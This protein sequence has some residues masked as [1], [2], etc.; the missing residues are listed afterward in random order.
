[1]SQVPRAMYQAC[2]EGY[3]RDCVIKFDEKDA[4]DPLLGCSSRPIKLKLSLKW[5]HNRAFK[6]KESA[7]EAR[8]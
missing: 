7:N 1:M 5:L 6:P 4:I 2:A 3:R 8:V